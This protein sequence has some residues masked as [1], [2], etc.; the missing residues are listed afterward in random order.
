MAR[1]KPV[2]TTPTTPVKS[3]RK[4]AAVDKHKMN[5]VDETVGVEDT[6]SVADSI[7]VVVEEPVIT[8]K[9][10][11]VVE[12]APC[13]KKPTKTKK[14]TATTTKKSGSSSSKKGKA[15][16]STKTPTPQG[17]NVILRLNIDPALTKLDESHNFE[18]AFLRYEPCV[19]IPDA[20]ERHD[21]FASQ[22]FLLHQTTVIDE[23]QS[24]ST[25]PYDIV[26]PTTF[27]DLQENGVV[28]AAATTTTT[29][30]PTSR[31]KSAAAVPVEKKPRIL[32]HLSEFVAR[33]DWPI[34]TTVHCFWC[35]HEFCNV[36][37]GIPTKY[38][39]DK[40]HVFGCFCSLE[41]AASY[42]FYSS[43][44]KHD[45]W[46]SYNLI[47]LLSR[48]LGYNDQVKLA[49]S[50]HVLKMFG[51]YMDIH[52]FRAFS[53]SNKVV[54]TYCYPMVAMIQQLEEVNNQDSMPQK[55]TFIPID[56]QKLYLL[57]N[58]VRLERQKPLH[59]GKNTLD[60]VMNLQYEPAD[61]QPEVCC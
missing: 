51:G 10:A 26:K 11:E 58:K 6:V 54:N 56:R 36:P 47:H 41:C 22:P 21:D 5:E 44:F 39:H 45:V 25:L 9:E 34:S 57:E 18:S 15:D 1:K 32:N 19:G 48:K 13:S 60:Q 20:F 33:D 52:E 38:I 30:K 42:N 27:F 49:P 35:C 29:T 17:E 4:A 23:Q 43:E 40:F 8:E 37:F 2:T 28:P 12:V 31:K 7:A 53:E 59:S 24:K 46:E 3:G 61:K 55:N 16:A 50:R 14:A